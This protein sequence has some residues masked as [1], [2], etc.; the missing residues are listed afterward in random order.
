MIFKEDRTA[1]CLDNSGNVF[2][3]RISIKH[4]K[5]FLKDSVYLP[6]EHGKNDFPER[7][8]KAYSQ[9]KA[10]KGTLT[11]IGASFESAVFFELNMPP[12][13]QKEMTQAL[14][15]ELSRHIP[16][17]MD[18]IVWQYRILDS[19]DE[20]GKRKIRIFAV[21]R[22][23]WEKFLEDLSGTNIE[24]DAF[25]YPFMIVPNDKDSVMKNID[26][27][28]YFSEGIPD[29]IGTKI[30]EDTFKTNIEGIENLPNRSIFTPCLMML[31]YMLTSAFAKDMKTMLPLPRKFRPKRMVALKIA[32]SVMAASALLLVLSYAGRKA[33]SISERI[34][35]IKAEKGRIYRTLA[36][37]KAENKKYRDTDEL[38]CKIYE[39]EEAD[40]EVVHCL[41][42]LSDKVPGGLWVT[43]FNS[44][45]GKIDVTL[46]TSYD[47]AGIDTEKSTSFLSGAG[48]AYTA[49]SVRKRRNGDGSEYLY[50]KIARQEKKM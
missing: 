18:Q 14:G 42:F 32:A 19:A 41:H 31:E 17:P 28:F 23:E 46:K 3:A 33:Y 34:A 47:D 2:A 1:I 15:F 29:I 27:S 36:Q 30:I 12:L 6:V 38:I 21:K 22:K 50:L 48:T 9:L 39:A 4:K 43:G 35:A 10:E 49:E 16:L 13:P 25:V 11:A 45:S 37:L 8:A 44:G 7:I 40:G 20:S 24:F 26:D 5:A